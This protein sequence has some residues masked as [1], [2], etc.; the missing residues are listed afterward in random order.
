VT[1]RQLP[2]ADGIIEYVVDGP[3][4][5]RQLLLFHLGTPC[6]AVPFDSLT[7]AAAAAGMRTA[8]YSRPGFGNSTRRAGR[9]IADE[10]ATS[11][12]LADHL[13]HDLF[14]TA[15]WSGGGPVALACAAIL[16]DRV[17]ACMTLGSIAPWH[18]AGA[19]SAFG[20]RPEDQREWEMLGSDDPSE[21]IPDFEQAAANADDRTAHAL[22]SNARSNDL[23]RSAILGPDRLGETISSSMRRA[24]L[25]GWQGHYDD[26]IAEA[27]PWGFRVA[28]IRVP[29]VVR[30]GDDDGWVSI[31]H[32]RWLARTIPGARGVFPPG[33]GHMSIL[34]PFEEVVAQLVE[35]RAR[36]ASDKPRIS[37]G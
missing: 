7:R 33:A 11:A 27:R 13:G 32:G 2:V 34:A 26:N 6:A 3:D 23:D 12:A 30:H 14:Y 18:E 17:R 9:M 21:L 36:Y 5:A 29:V 37:L 35:A 16:P 19:I 25:T 24:Y 22:A 10:A 1:Y 4:D 20:F 31:E 8:I 28:D 15:G